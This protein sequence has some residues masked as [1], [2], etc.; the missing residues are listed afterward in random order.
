MTYT[1]KTVIIN[2]LGAPASRKTTLA[3]E[4]FARLKRMDKQVEFTPEY[5]KKFTWLFP[6]NP[7]DEL[8]QSYVFGRELRQQKIL[9]GKVD[10]IISDSPLYLSAFYH[11]VR[12]G[13][14]YMWD[15]VY[16][17]INSIKTKYNVEM[18]NFFLGKSEDHNDNGRWENKSEALDLQ[19]F[20]KTWLDKN[21]IDYQELPL[22]TDERMSIILNKI[23]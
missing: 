5:V 16:K 7:P 1:N 21:N 3:A 12:S 17:V 23:L 6:D 11:E 9:F 22:D 8:D 14:S 10:Y 15:Y 13:E 20:L 2:L 4:L 19:V 18:V